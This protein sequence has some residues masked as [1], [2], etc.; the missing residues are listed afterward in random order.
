MEGSVF[1]QTEMYWKIQNL[2][3]LSKPVFLNGED[4]I[5]WATQCSERLAIRSLERDHVICDE[6][7]CRTVAEKMVDV[8]RM[9]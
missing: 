3:D 9:K 1:L 5:L 6:P 7:E 2:I 8:L 4:L